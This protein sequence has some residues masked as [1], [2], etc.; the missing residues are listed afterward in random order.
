MYT[1]YCRLNEQTVHCIFSVECLRRAGWDISLFKHFYFTISTPWRHDY[2]SMTSRF[3]IH[4]FTISTP[5]LHG[6]NSMTSRFQLHDVTISTPWLHDLTIS[7][8]HELREIEIVK[9][10]TTGR[11][12]ILYRTIL[13]CFKQMKQIPPL[14][15]YWLATIEFL[16]HESRLQSVLNAR[17][18]NMGVVMDRCILLTLACIG[19]SQGN[20]F[21]L[22]LRGTVDSSI[23]STNA[24][25]VTGNICV[26]SQCTNILKCARACWKD[27]GCRGIS[28]H[29]ANTM[30]VHAYWR[31]GKQCYTTP[32]DSTC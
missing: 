8:H 18:G 25:N 23:Y 4:E 2:N 9:H 30:Y 32:T 12:Y 26:A 13:L 6:F 3:Q 29:A 27:G 5:W 28:Y 11:S 24:T 1:Q 20:S 16:T 15:W 31:R 22:V 17:A 19:L 7:R 21:R 10:V 14:Q